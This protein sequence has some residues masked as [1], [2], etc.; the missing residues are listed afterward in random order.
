MAYGMAWGS[1]S[2]NQAV[3][4]RA[5]GFK[6]SVAAQASKSMRT[7]IATREAITTGSIT[8][9]GFTDGRLMNPMLAT[10]STASDKVRV[11]GKRVG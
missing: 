11:G 5:P 3:V 10:S 2:I 6:T 4:M 9:K 7:G 8:A 1:W